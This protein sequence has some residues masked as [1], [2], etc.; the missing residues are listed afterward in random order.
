MYTYPGNKDVLLHALGTKGQCCY[1]HWEQRDSG[2]TCTGNK[3]TVLLHALGT[4]G[5]WC[6]VQYLL[7][8]PVDKA[9]EVFK[10]PRDYSTQLMSERVQLRIIW[11]TCKER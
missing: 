4:K 9:E 1:M 7:Y 10:T 11:W 2:I 6:Y 3:G 8:F 5:Q